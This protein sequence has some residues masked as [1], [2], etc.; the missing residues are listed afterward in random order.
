MSRSLPSNP[1]L[2]SNTAPTTD[3]SSSGRFD[4]GMIRGKRGRE[5]RL[6]AHEG[7]WFAATDQGRQGRQNSHNQSDRQSSHTDVRTHTH[8]DRKSRRNEKSNL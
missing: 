2:S 4:E 3:Y 8:T 7:T 5:I 1:A 6:H